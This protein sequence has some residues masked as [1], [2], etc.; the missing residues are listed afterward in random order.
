MDVPNEPLPP[1]DPSL[2]PIHRYTATYADFLNA[3]RLYRTSS[4]RA[5]W[6]FLAWTYLVPAVT[7]GLC[8]G[9]L[10]AHRH[11]SPYAAAL[12]GF[13]AAGLWLTF[14]SVVLRPLTWRRAFRKLLLPGETQMN[15]EF[16][17]DDNGVFTGITS[18][19]EARFFWNSILRYAE[20]SE[21]ALLFIRKKLF[22][23]VPK[24]AM[25]EPEWKRLRALVA[26]HVPRY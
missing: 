19:S 6:A 4:R 10:Q 8:L 9:A 16:S 20:N 3:Q 21:I 7:A 24:R 26:Q 15:S 22:L 5:F 13:A 23:F 1:S 14:V 18:R 12:V 2:P 25:D 11:R 17:F